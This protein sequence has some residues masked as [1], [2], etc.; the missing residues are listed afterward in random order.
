MPHSHCHV[1]PNS[2]EGTVKKVYEDGKYAVKLDNG[3]GPLM[4][5]PKNMAL[6]PP[7]GGSGGAAGGVGGR[8]E[9][10][11]GARIDN[12]EQVMSVMSSTNNIGRFAVTSDAQL[13][14]SAAKPGKSFLLTAANTSGRMI[15]REE[16]ESGRLV[17]N[18]DF[19]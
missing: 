8:A 16:T 15:H 2:L 1:T 14:L 13:A 10:S 6:L 19:L 5:T 3:L 7:S 4:F 9:P 17:T 18:T 12:D 11:R